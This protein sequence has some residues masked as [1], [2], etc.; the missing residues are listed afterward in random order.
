VSARKIYF[1]L[2]AAVGVAVLAIYFRAGERPSA[3]IHDGTSSVSE[4]NDVSAESKQVREDVVDAPISESAANVRPS[5][6]RNE[7]AEQQTTPSW[8][9]SASRP[10]EVWNARGVPAPL[11]AQVDSAFSGEAIDSRWSVG[12]EADILREVT[13]MTGIKL[14]G[15]QVECRASMC[16]VQLTESVAL[17]APASEPPVSGV[18]TSAEAAQ[19]APSLPLLQELAATLGYERPVIAIVADGP[20]TMSSVAYLRQAVAR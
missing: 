5:A 9:T 16:R 13:Q 3:A 7:Q 18:L 10:L 15:I 8:P 1:S 17:R 20:G 4:P 6:G 19:I 14:I 11:L 2:A 12:M